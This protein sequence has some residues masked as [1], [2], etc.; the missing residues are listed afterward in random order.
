[1]VHGQNRAEQAQEGEARRERR[2]PTGGLEGDGW[3]R[4][5]ESEQRGGEAVQGE[6]Q[7]RCG[8][9]GASLAK[10]LCGGASSSSLATSA[11]DTAAGARRAPS[12]PLPGAWLFLL[13]LSLSPLFLAPLCFLAM[14]AA[15]RKVPEGS[16]VRLR[17]DWGFIEGLQGCAG[18][19]EAGRPVIFGVRAGTRGSHPGVRRRG[20]RG[21]QGKGA[22]LVVKGDASRACRAARL[23][24]GWRF[25]SVVVEWRRRPRGAAKR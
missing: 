5:G 6:P 22:A 19:G 18:L 4:S 25:R 13:L 1:V 3:R 24:R 2:R 16:R 23:T 21:G 17:L 8:R 7:R 12:P 10:V 9:T 11:P 20:L 15:E 14:P